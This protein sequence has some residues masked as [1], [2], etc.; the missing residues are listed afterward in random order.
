MN[1]DLVCDNLRIYDHAKGKVV[2]D[3]HY[4]FHNKIAPLTPEWLFN[5]DN[6]LVRHALGYVKP[7]VKKSFLH[8]R[9][10][11][12]D[13]VHLSGQDFIFLAEIVLSGARSFVIPEALYV[14]VHRIS[15]TTR[16]VSPHSHASPSFSLI[17]QGCDQ[18]LQKY[19]ASMKPSARRAL[20][21][22]RWIFQNR[23]QMDTAVAALRQK[24]WKDA[25]FTVALNPFILVLL[26]AT[27]AKMI[28]ANLLLL[29]K[30]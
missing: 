14:Y 7:M 15:P 23:V 10:I 1:A 9:N 13:P 22:R 26:A 18:L 27:L 2:E 6:P 4:G 17:V 30:S 25:A 3:T 19:R 24:R 20:L 16:K 21:L 5:G 29:T 8:A 28:Y 11:A 12:Y